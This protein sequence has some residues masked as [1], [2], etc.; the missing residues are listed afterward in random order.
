MERESDYSFDGIT[1]LTEKEFRLISDLIYS[2]FGI[3]LTEKKKALIRGRLHKLIRNEGYKSFEEYYNA[4]VNDKTGKNL[5]MM[6]DRLSTNHSFFFRES[7]HFDYL[8]NTIFPEMARRLERENSPDLKI[9][10]AGCAA[11]EE[12]YTL[13][14]IL[15]DHFDL[16]FFRSKPAILATDISITSLAQ[17]LEGEYPEERIKPVPDVY[18][19]KYL[20]KAG[21]G[22]YRVKD[23]LKK[24]ILFK[25]LNLMSETFP[26]KGKFH[27]IFCRNVMIYFDNETKQRLVTKFHNYMYD[28]G[29]LFI[30]HS[31]TLGR[32]TNLFRYIQPA[33][34]QK[35]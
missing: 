10:S 25:R 20:E 5:L 15:L 19:L 35:V 14:M 11:G 33:L 16:Q 34:Y 13:G 23:T 3:N 32:G 22:R 18:R 21:P 31:E 8:S 29:Y 24:L 2:K 7:E 6:V 28:N 26:F 12:P 1:Q 4:V 30:G 9:W 27:L 17:A